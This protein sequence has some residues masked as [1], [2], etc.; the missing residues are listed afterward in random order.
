[1]TDKA[2]Y[3][4]PALAV[5]AGIALLALERRRPLR[6]M[7]DPTLKRIACNATV[8][9]L[10]AISVRVLEK[11]MADRATERIAQRQAGLVQHLPVS[12]AFR[13]AA[14]VVLLDYTLYWWHVLLHRIP[15]LWRLHLP[16]HIDVDLDASTAL[17][18]HFLE[19]VASIPWRALQI[20]LIGVTPRALRAWQTLT[21]LEVVFH[22]SNVRL[23]VAWE[24]LLMGFVV[25]PR[26]HGVHHSRIREERDSNFSSGL[27]LWDRLHGTLRTG[28]LR[29]SAV[30]IPGYEHP[31]DT[32]LA[33]TL[34]LPF[35]ARDE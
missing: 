22:H 23:P 35:H 26:L 6:P 1:M 19:F 29:Q 5:A 17:R 2:R 28:A 34:L 8:G 31:S 3:V 21:G 10:T 15:A 4:V 20:L 33:K 7:T 32:A 24:K 25:T 9:A 12:D 11:P 30:G 13:D 14:A 16:H 27:T 18:F